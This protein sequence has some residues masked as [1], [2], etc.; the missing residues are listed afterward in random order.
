M[1]QK[2]SSPKGVCRMWGWM[3]LAVLQLGLT[4]H[5]LGEQWLL[6]I[7]ANL[8]EF[9]MLGAASYWMIRSFNHTRTHDLSREE[10]LVRENYNV[11]LVGLIAL[12]ALTM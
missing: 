12:G 5:F 10:R 7:I 3:L 6:E 11:I 1:I 9:S 2:A 4:Y 8:G